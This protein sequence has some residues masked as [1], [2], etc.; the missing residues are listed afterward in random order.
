MSITENQK[1]EYR[2]QYLEKQVRELIDQIK[3]YSLDSIPK[4]YRKAFYE[5]GENPFYKIKKQKPAYPPVQNMFGSGSFE[6]TLVELDMPTDPEEYKKAW[7][8]VKERAKNGWPNDTGVTP[9]VFFPGV[10]IGFLI[11]VP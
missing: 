4:K 2:I 5:P 3:F 8:R 9:I 10:P 11:P 7:E 1:L 6:K